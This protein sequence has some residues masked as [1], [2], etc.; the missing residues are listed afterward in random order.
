MVFP[1]P[2]AFWIGSWP[3]RWYG[4]AYGVGFLLTWL[5]GRLWV[6]QKKFPGVSA[7]DLDDFVNWAMIGI[8]VGGRLGHVLLYYPIYYIQ[9]PWELLQVWKGGMAFHGGLLGAIVAMGLYTRIRQIPFLSFADCISC[10]APFGFFLGRLANFLNQELYGRITSMPWGV[11]F[12]EVDGHLRHPSQ[13]YEAGLEGVGL[14]L[15]L[16]YCMWF[17]SLLPGQLSSLFI[18]GYGV[19]RWICEYFRS[20]EEGMAMG[21]TIGQWYSLPLIFAGLY[22]FWIFRKRKGKQ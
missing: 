11:T 12:P 19:T 22:L 7:T 14:F 20:P 8:V 15:F 10:G 2:I 21:V 9:H 16:F 1:S 18:F 4:V 5:Y 3:V 17:R 6:R 13:L